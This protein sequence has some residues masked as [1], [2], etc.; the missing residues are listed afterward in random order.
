MF[1]F[2]AKLPSGSLPV[3]PPLDLHAIPI[4]PAVPS[5]RLC[6]QSCQTGN[7]SF[8]ETLSRE[9]PDFDLCLIEPTAMGWRVVDSE[10]IPDLRRHFFTKGIG[11][12]FAA[13]DVQV[14]H[15]QMDG[16]RVRVGQC[17]ADRHPGALEAR[18]IRRREGEV[19]PGL[20]LY[21]AENVGRSAAL[22]F[23]VPARF[24]PWHGGRSWSDIGVEAD[25][26]LIQTDYRFFR[27][28]GPLV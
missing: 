4:H 17:Q 1:A 20:R 22:V 6:P 26:L 18:T 15:H 16:L 5:F 28:I 19:T 7:A 27:D 11:Q 3:E 12:C 13:M 14:V 21:C 2:V 24:P 10:P 25:R 8:T 23:V 9:Y